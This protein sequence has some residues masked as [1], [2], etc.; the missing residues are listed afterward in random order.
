MD[1]D[2]DVACLTGPFLPHFLKVY[3]DAETLGLIA[4]YVR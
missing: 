2:L 4:R 3:E 1:H